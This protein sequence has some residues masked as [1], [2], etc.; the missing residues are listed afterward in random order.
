MSRHILPVPSWCI[1]TQSYDEHI[2]RAKSLGLCYRPGASCQGYYYGGIDL[3]PYWGRVNE[4][5]PVYA[6]ESGKVLIKSD[7]TGY[8]LHIRLSVGD[9]E[10]V[11]FAHLSRTTVKDGTRVNQGD[12][13][14]W[15]GST[16]NSTGKHLHWEIRIGGIPV[17]PRSMMSDM[18]PGETIPPEQFEIPA[19]HAPIDQ[20]EVVCT[21]PLAVRLGPSKL[22]A[23]AHSRLVQGTVVDVLDIRQV[24]AD[25]WLRV[26]IDQW[27]A[28]Y[29]QG[30]VY[31]TWLKK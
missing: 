15:M 9:N 16:G 28:A 24:G 5:I 17:D 20:F 12:Q 23:M 14:G 2:A 11:I 26:G 10:L 21:Y 1:E 18:P 19:G 30:E 3:A 29:Y 6:S 4:D 8:G 27:I 25:I 22:T 31:A 13:I 7:P